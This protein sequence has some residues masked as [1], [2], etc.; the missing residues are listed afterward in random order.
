MKKIIL[1]CICFGLLYSSG[2]KPEEYSNLLSDRLDSNGEAKNKDYILKEF[3]GIKKNVNS[4]FAKDFKK[5]FANKFSSMNYKEAKAYLDRYYKPNEFMTKEESYKLLDFI[6]KEKYKLLKYS[7]KFILY[8]F[9]ETVPKNSTANVLMS[10]SILQDNGF[11][12]HIKE[13][14]TGPSDNFKNFMF[15]WKDFISNYPIQYQ[16]KISRN[17]KLKL[18]PRFFKVYEVKKA[19]AMA[20]AECQSMIPEPKTCRVKYFIR[21]DVSLESFF[22]KI[23]TLDKTYIPYKK[24]LEA[25]GIY[26]VNKHEK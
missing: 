22:D 12:I 5:N 4:K 23:S 17:F 18:D 8:F 26:E 1:L 3:S 9:S 19:P 20:L 21:G 25:N 6:Y 15:S 2:F 13:Y 24:A 7:N 10:V 14:L 16:E 11:D